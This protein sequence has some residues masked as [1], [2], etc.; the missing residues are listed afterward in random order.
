MRGKAEQRSR[1]HGDKGRQP[2]VFITVFALARNSKH[3]FT[4]LLS[5]PHLLLQR[6]LPRFENSRNV[7]TTVLCFSVCHKT[8]GI[9]WTS[10][11]CRR[12]SLSRETQFFPHPAKVIG[13]LSGAALALGVTLEIF[14]Q[15][16]QFGPHG[17]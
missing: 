1:R 2:T 17:L 15:C 3:T 14:Q 9:D 12:L 10:L 8:R 5:G 11:G 4:L 6:K 16:D 13:R 7:E